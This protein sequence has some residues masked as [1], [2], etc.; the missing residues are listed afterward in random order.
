MGSQ[1]CDGHTPSALLHSTVF[2]EWFNSGYNIDGH[3]NPFYHCARDLSSCNMTQLAD[4]QKF[5]NTMLDL[6]KP[7]FEPNSPHGIFLTSCLLHCQ[8]GGYFPASQKPHNGDPT[9]Y[10]GLDGIAAF[11]AWYDGKLVAKTPDQPFPKGNCPRVAG[12]N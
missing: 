5:H 1:L 3:G 7:I 6:Y 8:S 2:Q 11:A 9:L 10:G 4:V 12:L